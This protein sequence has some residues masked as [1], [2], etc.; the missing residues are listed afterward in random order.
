MAAELAAFALAPVDAAGGVFCCNPAVDA[1]AAL[2]G[3]KSVGSSAVSSF[4]TGWEKPS[5]PVTELLLD[6][7]EKE[8]SDNVGS[9]GEIFRPSEN[10]TTRPG[11]VPIEIVAEG[12]KGTFGKSLADP[13]EGETLVVTSLED[14]SVASG[15]EFA[16]G[17]FEAADDRE[18]AKVDAACA[19]GI[20]GTMGTAGVAGGAATACNAAWKTD[21]R[22][23]TAD[24]CA[25]SLLKLFADPVE[26]PGSRL[27]SCA[28]PAGG[29]LAA[30][31]ASFST[32]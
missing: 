17:I 1:A 2:S 32:P 14:E 13:D 21:A 20:S 27:E 12:S 23:A 18:F 7:V 30:F 25:K 8:A 15:K 5:G 16:V 9:A 19:E 3:R 11:F 29:N 4:D 22:V 10:G 6:C 24:P 26:R 31:P 28:L